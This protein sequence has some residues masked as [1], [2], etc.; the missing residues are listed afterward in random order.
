MY[1]ESYFTDVILINFLDNDKKYVYHKVCGQ[2][3]SYYKL[4][5]KL[6]PVVVQG[7]GLSTI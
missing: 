5:S 4:S 1:G 6:I 7:L 3:L 2:L